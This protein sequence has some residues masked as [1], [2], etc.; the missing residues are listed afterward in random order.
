MYA[1]VCARISNTWEAW[2]NIL[3]VQV[4]Y[5]FVQMY[6]HILSLQSRH[7]CRPFRVEVCSG[8]WE[9]LSQCL[10]NVVVGVFP[11]S[12]L[13]SDLAGT[14]VWVLFACLFHYMS[15]FF[16]KCCAAHPS[17]GN[18]CRMKLITIHSVFEIPNDCTL[19]NVILGFQDGW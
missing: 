8:I 17:V 7:V 19:I 14:A 13:V 9:M 11:F 4:I 16:P 15:A 5:S 3:Y 18:V 2:K 1:A 12:F 6:T 10:Y